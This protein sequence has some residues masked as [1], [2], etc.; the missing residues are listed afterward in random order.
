MSYWYSKQ[1]ILWFVDNIWYKE[2]EI[3]SAKSSGP[4]WQ[5]V[6]KNETKMQ[7]SWLVKNTTFLPEDF[8]DKLILE[9]KSII[10]DEWYLRLDAQVH[11][12]QN[13]NKELLQ[14]KLSKIIQDVF[15]PPKAPRKMTEPPKHAVDKRIA[16]KKRKSKSRASRTIKTRF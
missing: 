13:A 10:N 1:K 12:T 4:W 16:E 2:A 11:R 7:L 5:N 8:R 6:N 3:S 9:H 14:K 15:K